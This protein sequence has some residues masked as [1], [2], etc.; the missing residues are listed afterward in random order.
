MLYSSSGYIE[1]AHQGETGTMIS[2][3]VSPTIY[4]VGHSDHDIDD[5]IALLQSHGVDTVVDV[6]SQPYS[7]WVPAYN[8][9]TL[10]GALEAAGLTYLFMG[11]ALGGRPGD[12]S[13]YDPG[14]MLPDYDR[15]AATAVFQEGIEALIE[16]ACRASVVIMCSEGD[17][18]QCHR[19]RLITPSLLAAEVKV[20]HIL[21]DGRTVEAGPEFRQLSLF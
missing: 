10:Q 12:P 4:T 9:E 2:D 11:E 1:T 8:R 5:F 20:I 6:R 21:S 18:H 15:V 7:R 16:L 19:A 13:L 14:T 17:H 3:R